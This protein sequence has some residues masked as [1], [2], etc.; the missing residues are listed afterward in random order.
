MALF[1]LHGGQDVWE[2]LKYYRMIQILT[3]RYSETYSG[4]FIPQITKF[5]TENLILGIY[6]T[7]TFYDQI[8]VDQ[9]MHFPLMVTMMMIFL[10]TFYPKDATV[11]ETTKGEPRQV[12]KLG[13]KRFATT[14]W[15]RPAKKVVKSSGRKV[16]DVQD[17][18]SILMK[19]LKNRRNQS[20]VNSEEPSYVLPGMGD[21]KDMKCIA[22]SCPTVGIPFGSLYQIKRSTVLNLFNFIACNTISTLLT[23]P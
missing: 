16:M 1:R 22:K 8:P 5:A 20:Q 6:G 14:V 15:E 19:D 12:L 2:N 7:V 11:Y 21:L 13:L 18:T 23:Y 9:Y 4:C 10:F 17:T 3:N